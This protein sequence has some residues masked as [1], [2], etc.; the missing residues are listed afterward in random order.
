VQDQGAK[1]QVKVAH[2]QPVQPIDDEQGKPFQSFFAEGRWLPT[3]DPLVIGPGNFSELQ[4]L[5]HGD[6]SRG[7]EGVPGYTK[8]NTTPLAGYL[9]IRSGIQLTADFTVKS[10]ILVQAY[11]AGLTASQVLQNK[12]AIPS[13]GNFEAAAL[14]TDAAGAGL[15]R[16]A[17]W[18]LSQVAYCNGVETKIYGGDETPCAAF[19]TSSAPV[20]TSVLTNPK[21]FTAQVRNSINAAD[22]CA[23]MVRTGFTTSRVYLIGFTRPISGF[24]PYLRTVNGTAAAITVKEWLGSAWNAVSGMVDG[25]AAGGKTHA[26]TGQPISWDS[27]VATS[28]PKY[29]MGRVLYWYQVELSAGSAEIYQITVD[30]PFQDV[31]D[32]WDGT[33]LLLGS[34]LVYD[35]ASGSYSD[36][37]GMASVNS[38][39]TLVEFGGLGATEHILFGAPV[40]LMGFNIRMSSDTAK[41]NS[42]VVN[43]AVARCNGEAIASW[44]TVAG[45][46][47]G[48]SNG[49]KSLRQGGVVSYSPAARGEAFPV[50]IN[51]GSP[52]YYYKLTF[53]G[54]V[55]AQGTITMSGIATADETFL[56][57]TQT[58]VWKAARTGAGEVTIGATTAAACANLITAINL[59][60]T[61]VVASA[62]TGDKVIVTAAVAGL[63]GNSIDF[64]ETSTNMTVDGTGHLGGT[65]AGV[66][67]PGLSA[68]VTAY[69]ITGIPAPQPVKPY[70]FPF[71]FLG[72][73]ML[74]GD[75][76]GGNGGLVDYG[77]SGATDVFN[78][79]DASL[80][81]ENESLQFGGTDDLTAAIEVY[82]RLGSSIYSFG[83][84]CKHYETYILNGYDPSTFRPYPISTS[85]GCPAPLTMDTWQIGISADG[86]AVR[87]IAAWI[88]H[89]GPVIFDSGG[90]QDIPGLECYFDKGDPRCVNYAAIGNSRGW[91]DP[92]TGDYNVQIPSGA[93]QVE[94]NVWVA[95]QLQ[96]DRK[97]YHVVPSAAPAPYL[98]AAFRV[99]DTSKRAYVYGARDNGY[100]M[101]LHNPT[102]PTW[103]GAAAVQAV[104]LGDL[105]PS[106]NVWEKV[107]VDFLKIFGISIA[108][109]IDLT[110]THYADG[111]A[112]GTALTPVALNGTNRYWKNTQPVDIAAWSH[113]FKLSATVTTTPKGLQLLGWGLEH[114]TERED[115]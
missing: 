110:V 31:R 96:S 113:S 82:N 103:D 24:T 42:T 85:K 35:S 101:R 51:G 108:E 16:F 88:S 81:V 62:G 99:E 66:D 50:S 83:I 95:C 2:L 39:D 106:G 92:D 59:D 77:L 107:R 104:T 105:V 60:M 58:F 11:N 93:G 111:A 79:P 28:V 53:P 61:T 27:T 102:V 84:F 5:R 7:I 14:H 12:T 112:T 94:N 30:A 33:E 97:W 90:L 32:V 36:F 89:A 114:H 1:M 57:D 64:T 100:L 65:T 37:T 6:G 26:L 71:Q 15:G 43:M 87:S 17:K 54:P 40:D 73:P 78:G 3:P 46:D 25:T 49:A 80:G 41:V 56:I 98:G 76:A 74:C 9:K 63:A 69:Y 45:L 8:I 109:D 18:P 4:N 44:P 23:F 115:H 20:T 47:D 52:M 34:V 86:Q 72:R 29:I 13:Q 19:F 10:R 55:A 67:S 21:N 75:K 91:F 48:T 22:Q 70:L 68:V 38:T